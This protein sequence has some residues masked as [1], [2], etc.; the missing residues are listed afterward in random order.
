VLFLAQPEDDYCRSKH[1]VL[2]LY[3]IV[4]VLTVI[5]SN[6][7]EYIDKQRDNFIQIVKTKL[8]YGPSDLCRC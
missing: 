8:L 7:I 4:V 1:V 5:Y 3:S 2:T 6:K